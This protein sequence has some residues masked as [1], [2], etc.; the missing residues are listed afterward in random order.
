MEQ[1]AKGL[2]ASP[3]SVSVTLNDHAAVS[4]LLTSLRGSVQERADSVR[5]SIRGSSSAVVE[6][7]NR[8]S[9]PAVQVSAM[10]TVKGDVPTLE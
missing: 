2:R 8:I 7:L 3:A 1:D 4:A 5:V 10:L 6:F 9:D